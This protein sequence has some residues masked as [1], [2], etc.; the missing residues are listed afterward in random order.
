MEKLEKIMQYE[1]QIAYIKNEINKLIKE[2]DNNG[3][4]IISTKIKGINQELENLQQQLNILENNN[5]NREKEQTKP[6]VIYNKIDKKIES[7]Q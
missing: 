5:F 2:S 6:P 3:N 1:Q 7:N 4:S